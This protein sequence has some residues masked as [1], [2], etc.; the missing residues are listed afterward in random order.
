[1]E[2]TSYKDIAGYMS[3]VSFSM[4]LSINVVALGKV[5]GF[6]FPGDASSWTLASFIFIAILI[7]NLIVFL[8]KG[9]YKRIV[10]NGLTKTR[11]YSYITVL[12]VMVSVAALVLV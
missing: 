11:K 7:L 5:I 8:P 9:K 3:C 2:K 12:Y 4:F 10:E 1:M 6:D